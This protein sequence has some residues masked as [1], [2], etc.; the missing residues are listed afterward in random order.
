ML[1]MR[2]RIKRVY[3]DDHPAD[4][5]RI[6]VDRLW[7]RGISKERARIHHWAKEIAP[8]N[9]LRKWYQH[10][11]RKWD[12]FKRRYYNELNAKP[13]ALEAFK[14][15]LTGDTV[16]FLFSATERELNN[17]AALKAYVE[18]YTEP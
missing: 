6:L 9:E 12:E 7:P 1:I 18:S 5:S 4:G 15:Q 3:E 17:A 16:T 11:P 8:S 14:A 2:I 13:D 10:D